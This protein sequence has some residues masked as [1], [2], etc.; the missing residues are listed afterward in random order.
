[1]LILIYPPGPLHPSLP[2]KSG[3]ALGQ[4]K[5]SYKSNDDDEEKDELDRKHELVWMMDRIHTLVD[6]ILWT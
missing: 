3:D 4:F 1:M 2:Y 6:R 5:I